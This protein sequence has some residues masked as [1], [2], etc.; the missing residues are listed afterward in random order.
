HVRILDFGL[1]KLRD[2][3][4]DQS[5][6]APLAVGTPS[7]MSPE[8]AKGKLVDAR[9]D[10]YSAGVVLFELI[11]GRKPFVADAAMALHRRPIEV[12]P[13]HLAE[14]APPI[15]KC[16]RELDAVIQKALAKDPANRY[17]SAVELAEALDG[18][19]EA[20]VAMRRGRIEEPAAPPPPAPTRW[21]RWLVIAG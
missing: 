1:A 14:V 11:A 10:V 6:T 20:R 8:Q 13:P 9:S 21:R 18:T 3:G 15:R 19:P 7:Y 12:A 2:A 4:A 17:Q 16:S 5:Q